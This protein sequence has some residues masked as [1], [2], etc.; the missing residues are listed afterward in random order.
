MLSRLPQPDLESLSIDPAELK[1][2]EVL[3]Q[4]ETHSVCRL[5]M[6]YGSFILKW[7]DSPAT[8]VEPQVYQLLKKQGVATLPVYKITSQAILLEDLQCSPDWRQ[9]LPAD[10]GRAE[11]GTAI[12]V[13]Y[14]KLHRAGVEA[15][16]DAS[17][18]SF[19]LPWI[20]EISVP[21]L[22][23]AG[24]IFGF[25]SRPDWISVLENVEAVKSKYLA[26]SQTFNYNDFAAENLALSARSQQALVFDYDCFTTGAAASDWRNVTK[27]LSG[28]ARPAFK[29]AYG[30]VDA[31]ALLLDSPL[32]ILYGLVNASRRPNLPGWA[33][34]LIEAVI[35][36]DLERSFSR[37]LAA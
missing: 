28:A 25:E 11:T 20:N 4:S 6:P 26:L 22:Y 31:M 8:S 17:A 7:F 30:H 36:G 5:T 1:A 12:A 14:L 23:T 16:S 13:W 9:A 29:E 19:L 15:L 33:L 27:A 32:D 21:A 2:V 35:D 24:T 34:S 3:S 10:L 18:P 37:A